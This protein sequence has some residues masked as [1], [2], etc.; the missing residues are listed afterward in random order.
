[1]YVSHEICSV[2]KEKKIMESIESNFQVTEKFN[3]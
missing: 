3:K 2:K 1:M